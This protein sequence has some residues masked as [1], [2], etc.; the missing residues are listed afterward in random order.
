MLKNLKSISKFL[1]LVLRHHPEAIGLKLDAE[2][3]ANIEDLVRLAAA[4]GRSVSRGLIAEVVRTSEKQRFALKDDGNYIRANQ[5]HSV[6]VNLNLP[7]SEP[8]EVLY[9]GTSTR[10]LNSIKRD[11][12]ESRGRRYVHLSSNA[13]TARMVGSRHGRPVVL[14][15]DAKQMHADGFVFFLSENGVWL[16]DGVPPRYIS[17]QKCEILPEPICDHKRG[18]SSR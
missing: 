2:G 18:D 11:G 3:W 12:L 17:L 13:H 15:V 5:G 16:T 9:H 6:E 8:P 4:H 10:F 1:S 14:K 7:P